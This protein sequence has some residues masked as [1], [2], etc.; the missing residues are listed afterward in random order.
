MLTIPLP[1]IRG[2]DLSKNLVSS[3][4]TVALVAA[5]LPALKSLSL[6]Y[7]LGTIHYLSCSYCVYVLAT[8][9]WLCR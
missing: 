6:K 1:G 4:D 3:W 8:A 7:T 2:L 9:V 5:E